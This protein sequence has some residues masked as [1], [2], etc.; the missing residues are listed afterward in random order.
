VVVEVVRPQREASTAYFDLYEQVGRLVA[1]SL[2]NPV[3][4]REAILKICDL[5]FALT[6][7]TKATGDIA[8]FLDPEG[9]FFQARS[10]INERMFEV[11]GDGVSGGNRI[12][13]EI[14]RIMRPTDEDKSVS[15]TRV[16]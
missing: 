16:V 14:V 15:V 5:E 4:A 10:E 6:G 12:F 11:S 2:E 13:A 7:D 3:K 8:E 1:L 9:T